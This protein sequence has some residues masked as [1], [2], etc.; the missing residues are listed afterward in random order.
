MCL[1]TTLVV[2]I[3]QLS[4]QIFIFIM[5]IW[6]T[7][8][9]LNDLWYVEVDLDHQSHR[10]KILVQ[11]QCMLQ[12]YGLFCESPRDKCA[13]TCATKRLMTGW[14]AGWLASSL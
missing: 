1:P 2:Q 10:K 9:E 3:K 7:T 8:F 13:R 6:T 11:F 14:I 4:V 5:C 12:G